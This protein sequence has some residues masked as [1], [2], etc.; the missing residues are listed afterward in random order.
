V[1]DV[2]VAVL[3]A[4]VLSP[5]ARAGR[6]D[7]LRRLFPHA[8]LVTTEAVRAELRQGVPSH[9]ALEDALTAPWLETEPIDTPF[10]VLAAFARHHAA[11]GSTTRD[12]GEATVLAYAEVH[13]ALAVIDDK[14]AS[15]HGKGCGIRT[16]R[17]LALIARAI[18]DGRL[19][20]AAARELVD[21]LQALGGARLGCSGDDVI[22]W[23]RDNDL[24]SPR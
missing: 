18:Q 23:F 3:D 19:G 11:F 2:L 21:A 24:L 7:D 15:N 14:V 20:E 13:G 4:S 6:L 16:V 17:T 12:V 1:N 9:P 22:Q 10:E 5:F 8:R